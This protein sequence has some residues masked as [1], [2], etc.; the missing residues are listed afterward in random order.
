MLGL[1]MGIEP[2]VAWL[3]AAASPLIGRLLE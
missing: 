2:F 3:S 1:V